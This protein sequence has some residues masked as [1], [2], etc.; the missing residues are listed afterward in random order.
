MCVAVVLDIGFGTESP[1]GGH[2]LCHACGTENRSG[3]KFCSTCGATLSAACPACGQ[4]NEPAD[5]FCGDCGAA[6]GGTEAPTPVSVSAQSPSSAE[7]KVVSVLFV[8][9]VGF[10]SL[11]EA[12]DAE[13]VRELLTRYFD[14]SRTLIARYGGTIEKFIGDAVMAVWGAPIAREDDAERAVRAALELTAA[15]ALIGEEAATEGLAAR[16]G[17]ATGEAAVTL[18]AVGQGMVAGDLVNTAARVQSAAE[19]GSVFVT[20]PTRRASEASIVYEDAGSHQMK[21]KVEPVALARALRVISGRAGTLR[22]VGLESPFVGRDREL[23]LMKEQFHSVADEGKAHLLAVTG[24]GGIGKSRL[25]WEFFKYMDGLLDDVWWHR[26]R[27]IAYGDGVTYWALAEMVR[28][29]AGI[30]EEEEPAAAAEK[31]SRCVAE[32]VQDDQER[33]FVETRLG[34]LLGFEARAAFAREDLFA[35][36]RMF[37]ERIADRGPAVLVFEDLQWGD[38]S[39]LD[40]IEYLHD[41]SRGHRLFI[42]TLARPELAE[43]RPNWAAGRRGST[44]LFLEPLS[45][46]VMDELLRGM[47]PG[48]PD[49]LAA[50]IRDRAEGIPLYA[51]ETVRMLLDRGALRR[52]GPS[53]EL[54]GPVDE[55]DVPETLQALI[56]ARLDGLPPEER[57]LVQ[58]A[59]VLGKTFTRASLADVTG[60]AEAELEPLL[61]SLVRKELLGIQTDSR[62]PERGQYGFLQSLTQKVAYDT[63]SKRDRKAR[64]LAAA[65]SIER[66]WA[67]DEDEIVEVVASHYLEA[68]RLAPEADDAGAIRAKARDMLVRAGRR[69]EALAATQQARGFYLRAGELADSTSDRAELIEAAAFMAFV[70]GFLDQAVDLYEQARTAFEEE[71]RQHAAARVSARI[72]EILWIRDRPEEGVELMERAFGVLEQDEPDH[73]LATLAATLGKVLFF[74]G[75]L[76]DAAERIDAALR[77]AEPQWFPD[78]LSEALN[79]KGLILSSWGRPE[80]SLALLK[81]SLEIALENDVIFSAIRAYINL[82]NEMNDRDRLDE[83]IL[84]VEGGRALARRY[85]FRGMDWFLVGHEVAYRWLRGEWDEVAATV[86]GLPDPIEEPALLAGIEVIAWA[87]LLVAAERGDLEEAERCFGYLVHLEDGGDVQSRALHDSTRATLHRAKGEHEEALNWGLRAVEVSGQLSARHSAVREGYAE[88]LA[89][90]LALGRLDHAEGLLADMDAVPPGSTSPSIRAISE[91][92]HALI[93]AQRGAN[94]VEQRFKTA[95]R[96]LRE[97][98]MPFEL[99]VVLLGHGEWLV[100]ADRTQD[101]I[102]ILSEARETF[103]RLGA[104][105]YLDRLAKIDLKLTTV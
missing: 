12:R 46:D 1:P 35:G 19:P 100:S 98:D 4:P 88:A 64:H 13:E 66:S 28:M 67:S 56:A 2:L 14:T 31:L 16:A 81:R 37:F 62:S 55:L 103:E 74:L 41:W 104:A 77:I 65:A 21:G 18:G 101:A 60:R 33:R 54:A 82:S 92:F 80:E 23:R 68:Y 30:L 57:T 42:V 91:R 69:A 83:A 6:L 20:E 96:L 45:D 78:V 5:L 43:R 102:P 63:L 7:R 17:V 29:R 93:G 11:S 97:V 94:D 76:D 32:L 89:A 71:G 105:P 44:S 73:D 34:H 86:R 53:F 49:E 24:V 27:C 87:G 39:L 25:S 22:S 75:R 9:L 40:F 99:A 90:D 95:A 70:G 85:G 38:E 8:D 36:W 51:V 10:T 50:K 79:T 47:V 15:V 61:S 59:A 26:G 84:C 72:G 48:L 52:E 3:R 58:D